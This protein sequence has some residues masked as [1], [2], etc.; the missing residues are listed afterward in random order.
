MKSTRTQLM[1]ARAH[2]FAGEADKGGH[3]AKAIAYTSEAIAEVE[4]A[5]KSSHHHH[6]WTPAAALSTSTSPEATFQGGHMKKALIHLKQS[7]EN[8]GAAAPDQGGHRAKA[9]ELI[10]KAIE[11]VEKANATGA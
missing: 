2:L 4:A 7:K 3:R 1:K 11:E 10:D 5:M 8:L 6:A 9:M